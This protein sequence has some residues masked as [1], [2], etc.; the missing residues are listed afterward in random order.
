MVGNMNNKSI[1]R[2]SFSVDILWLSI[3]LLILLSL[4]LLLPLSPQDYWWYLRLGQD[5]A[6]TGVRP[7]DGHV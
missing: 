1:L 3:A 6:N 5:V 2:P 4:A 7:N